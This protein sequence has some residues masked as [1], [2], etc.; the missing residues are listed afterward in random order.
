MSVPGIPISLHDLSAYIF[1][2]ADRFRTELTLRVQSEGSVLVS[3]TDPYFEKESNVF[4][5]VEDEGLMCVHCFV[6]Q[7]ALLLAAERWSEELF[8]AEYR[9]RLVNGFPV[10]IY[11]IH[12]SDGW[13]P[14]IE[15]ILD[16]STVFFMPVCPACPEH[17]AR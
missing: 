11:M 3:I 8:L 10:E 5:L 1:D 15:D 17:C 2:N 14:K 6:E 7:M 13:A 12:M 4:W 9:G 16:S